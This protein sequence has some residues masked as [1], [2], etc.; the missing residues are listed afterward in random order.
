MPKDGLTARRQGGT[1]NNEVVSV[2]AIT[3]T[4]RATRRRGL[5]NPM[6]VR[7]K[8]KTVAVAP[9]TGKGTTGSARE[10]RLLNCYFGDLVRNQRRSD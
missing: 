6:K 1:T 2:L 10:G 4:L 3:A 7:R 8:E 9:K 5:A